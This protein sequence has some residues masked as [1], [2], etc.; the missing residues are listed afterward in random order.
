MTKKILVIIPVRG[1]S[2]RLKN[3]NILP[4]KNIPMFLFVANNIKKSKNNLRIVIS[5]EDSKI[6]KICQKNDIEYIRRPKFL[7]K[8]NIEK[9][10]TIV[11]ATKYLTKKENFFRK[12]LFRY[13]QIHL[14]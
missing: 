3:K 9:Q 7:S 1:N 5:S 2:K 10:D 13:K 12:L 6:L 11:H 4:I 8:D 14:K